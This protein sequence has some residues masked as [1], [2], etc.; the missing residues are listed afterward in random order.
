MIKLRQ[1][2]LFVLV[3]V[4]TTSDGRNTCTLITLKDDFKR[5]SLVLLGKALPS[6]PGTTRFRTIRAWKGSPE[7]EVVLDAVQFQRRFEPGQTV[8]VFAYERGDGWYLHDCSHTNPVAAAF[9]EREIRTLDSRSRWW[10][11]P[12]S[13][14][15]LRRR[16]GAP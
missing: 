1:A 4:A 13:S 12:I 3:V 16:P 5:A 11:C 15:S 7:P 14:F 6:D 10:N 2:A 9:V 8:L